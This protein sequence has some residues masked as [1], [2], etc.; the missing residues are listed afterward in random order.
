MSDIVD[1]A[2]GAV[3]ATP[4]PEVPPDLLAATVAAVHSRQP[5]ADRR[6][7][8]R[9]IMRYAGATG[10]V[11]AAAVVLGVL[12]TGGRTIAA[13][14]A[15]GRAADA[16]RKVK[17]Y[18]M[19][20]QRDDG[21]KPVTLQ[22]VYSQGQR[23]RSEIPDQHEVRVGDLARRTM[24][25]L[26]AREKTAWTETLTEEEARQQAEERDAG[27]PAAL[28]DQ[29][30]R[31]KG[32]TVKE[33]PAERLAGREARV[34]VATFAGRP[35]ENRIWVDSATNLPVRLR[36]P[37]DEG[38]HIVVELDQ[39]DVAFDPALFALDP[40]AGYKLTD[41][42]APD[43]VSVVSLKLAVENQE[44]AKTFRAVTRTTF[45]NPPPGTPPMP[46]SRMYGQGAKLRIEIGTDAVTV[47]DGEAKKLVV[48][49]HKNKIART[50]S[51]EV[52][53]E[54]ATAI[55][56]WVKRMLA[57]D[58]AEDLGES[59]LD[60]RKVHGYRFTKMKIDDTATADVT[61]YVDPKRN[62]PVRVDMAMT[63]GPL[64]AGMTS[65][66]DYLGFDEELDPKLFDLTPPAG[67]KV[68]VIDPSKLPG[69]AKK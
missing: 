56:K 13:E 11:A 12:S 15:I 53:G 7:R 1:R 59:F 46:E 44:K 60:G 52:P 6:A 9:R 43:R 69:G 3:R 51:T 19:V 38:Q 40:P 41:E 25:H 54:M 66:I 14:E 37:S 62:L 24:L 28:L 8:R 29:V 31:T 20:M 18:R 67:Y 47:G 65:R 42:P 5:L 32:V 34:Y 64:P 26:D 68:E 30:R 36:W 61:Y 2:A 17:S 45:V 50:M 48:L 33:L 49:D 55:T 58:G 35:G 22:I 10:L 39:W 16:A 27:S 63:G 4:T 23:V 21:R 57:K